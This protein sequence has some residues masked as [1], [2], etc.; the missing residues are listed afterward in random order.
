MLNFGMGELIVILII[1]MILFGAS[2]V[3]EIARAL[4]RSIREFKN[5]TKDIQEEIKT[6]TKDAEVTE[7]AEEPAAQEKKTA[8]D[9]GEGKKREKTKTKKA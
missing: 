6:V 1:V 5:A 4:G 8:E 3:P 2:K 7:Q 9:T